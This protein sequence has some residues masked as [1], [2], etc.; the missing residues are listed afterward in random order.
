MSQ[1]GFLSMRAALLAPERVR[2]LVL[3]DTQS[4]AEDPERLPAYRQMQETWLQLGPVD[5]LAQ[6]IAELIIGDPA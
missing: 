6:A 4:G 3:I 5:E 2:A 1:G